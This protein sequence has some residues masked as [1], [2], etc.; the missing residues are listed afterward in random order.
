MATEALTL[1][2]IGITAYYAWETRRMRQAITEPALILAEKDWDDDQGS[3]RPVLISA[4]QQSVVV[5]DACLISKTS[6]YRRRI[7]LDRDEGV[8]LDDL[9]AIIQ[10][11]ELVWLSWGEDD[12]RLP[13]DPPGHY[14]VR[15]VFVY[16]AQAGMFELI[17]EMQILSHQGQLVRV[18]GQ[19]MRRIKPQNWER[20]WAIRRWQPRNIVL[21]KR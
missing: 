8:R 13:D 21:K 4:S 2:L 20:C 7:S 14:L 9:P 17:G 3:V 6:T 1:A 12:S 18:G 15:I 5:L 11:G 16:G 19:K 10:P